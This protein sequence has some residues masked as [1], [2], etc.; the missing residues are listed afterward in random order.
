MKD[1]IITLYVD[2]FNM[3]FPQL[4]L[5]VIVYIAVLFAIFLDLIA[6]VKKAKRNENYT[7]SYGY[8]RTITKVAGYFLFLFGMT[9]IDVLQMLTI[10]QLNQRTGC[11]IPLIPLITYLTGIFVVFIEMKSVYENYDKKTR[12]TL[13]CGAKTAI[14]SMQVLL[15]IAKEK[16]LYDLIDKI[17]SKNDKP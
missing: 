13:K 17:L 12:N 15:K 1:S 4:A 10:Y 16:E 14:D 6:G 3:M 7:T 2:I 9:I 8:R 11:S 5:L